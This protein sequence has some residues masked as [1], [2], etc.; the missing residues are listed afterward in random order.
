MTSHATTVANPSRAAGDHAYL[1]TR[2]VFGDVLRY[3]LSFE[4]ARLHELAALSH[5]GRAGKT[6]V[7]EGSLRIMQLALQKGMQLP[8]Q[9]VGGALSI[10]VLRG[11]LQMTTPDGKMDLVPGGLVALNR[12]VPHGAVAMSDCVMLITISLQEVVSA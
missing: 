1:R 11:R 8:W 3:Q 5:A 2:R 10:Q 12:L 4:E 9:E 6:L 7:K